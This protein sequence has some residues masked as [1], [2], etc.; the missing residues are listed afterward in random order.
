MVEINLLPWRFY[1][2]QNKKL[3]KK[4]RYIFTILMIIILWVILHVGLNQMIKKHSILLGNLKYQYDFNQHNLFLSDQEQ[5][6]QILFNKNEALEA[7]WFFL[8]NKLSLLS[9]HGMYLDKI[10][11]SGREVKIIIEAKNITDVIGWVEDFNKQSLHGRI[12][13]I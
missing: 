2:N 10:N 1:V 12:A 13:R 11:Y 6:I 3:Q 8:I 7:D 4:N 9:S 5:K